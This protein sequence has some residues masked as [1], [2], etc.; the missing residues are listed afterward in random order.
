MLRD[1]NTNGDKFAS[2]SKNGKI[3]IWS[4]NNQLVSN[5]TELI[6]IPNALFPVIMWTDLQFSNTSNFLYSPLQTISLSKYGIASMASSD[7][8]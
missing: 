4:I 8:I 2:A 5:V 7:N 3:I 1:F 6:S